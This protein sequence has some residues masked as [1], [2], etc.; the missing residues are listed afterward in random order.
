MD[1]LLPRG[2]A[3]RLLPHPRALARTFPVRPVA[4]AGPRK[5]SRYALSPRTLAMADGR[6]DDAAMKLW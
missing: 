4:P 3:T 2:A 1:P 5:G 6:C